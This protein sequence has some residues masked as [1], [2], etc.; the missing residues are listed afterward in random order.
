M[1]SEIRQVT[2][3]VLGEALAVPTARV[4]SEVVFHHTWSPTATQYRGIQTWAGIKRH[5]IDVRGWSDIGYHLG[6]GPDSSIWLL[7]PKA[8]RGAHCAGH[9]EHSMGIVLVGNYDV[10]NPYENGLLTAANVVAAVCKQYKIA[11][12]GVFFHRDFANKTCPGSRI[13]TEGFRLLVDKAW[14][15]EA[16]AQPLG[17]SST[18]KT[19][20]GYG[21]GPIKVIVMKRQAGGGFDYEVVPGLMREGV[22]YAAI[23]EYNSRVGLNRPN[24]HIP[25]QR[26]VY[27]ILQH[28]FGT[29]TYAYAEKDLYPG[30]KLDG[31][32]GYTCYGV[33]KNS[34]KEWRDEGLP[35][36]LSNDLYLRCS[37]KKDEP[38]LLKD[39]TWNPKDPKFELY[40]RARQGLKNEV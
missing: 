31:L 22:A 14:R 24:D 16:L 30:Q 11:P 40:A 18:D 1:Q 26:K 3:N 17:I 28:G 4:I 21:D 20:G 8:R 13:S 39:T 2:L 12:A 37:V 38:I 32:G 15:G 19:T 10:E 9:N 29:E 6:V 35:I 36:H 23:R 5:H 7:R 34:T 25:D 33:V 27:V